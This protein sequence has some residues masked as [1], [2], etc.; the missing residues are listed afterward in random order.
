MRYV[1]LGRTAL[2]VSEVCLGTLNLG[3]RAGEE[4]SHALLDV[5]LGHGVNFVDTANQYGWQK[6]K[7]YTEELL[8]SW[9]A[10]GGGRRE[11][12]VLGTKVANP[13]SDWP[14][15]SGLSARHIIASC[16]DSLRRLRTDWI[17]LFQMHHVDRHAPWEEVWQAMEHLT[18]QGKVRYVGSSNF[19]GWH[20][21]EAQESAVRRN[22]LG[23]VSEQS[24]YNLVTRHVELEVIPACVRYGVAV[25]PW[26]PLHGGLLGGALR[27]LSEGTAMKSSQGRAA[28]ALRTHRGAVE[29]YERLC[30][31][32]GADPAEVGL[33][34]VMSRPGV[35][36][37]VIGPR[38]VEQLEG[39]L[40]ATR[41]RLTDDVLAALDV[42]FP[43]VGKGG[44]G[45]EA[46]AW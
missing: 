6:Y 23:I 3:V 39:A 17:D 1:R 12:V 20:I 28:E 31:D 42:L 25:L 18:G 29:G 19:A 21:A 22:F 30:A 32:L 26:S 24:V 10:R 16:E 44:P 15:D 35:T 33:A 34:W 38:S 36:A 40:R 9:F 13:M 41:I 7:G 45:P 14:N 27:K 43:P 5:A 37:P 2:E 11:K 4:E 8:G 46:W